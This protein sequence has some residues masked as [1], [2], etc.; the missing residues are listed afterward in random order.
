MKREFTQR[1]KALLLALA[2]ILLFAGY[3]KLFSEPVEEEYTAAQ[4]QYDHVQGDLA[5]EQIKLSSMKKM[6]RTL[7]K[8]EDS[9]MSSNIMI[10]AYDNSGNV[11]VQ[12]DSILKSAASYQV[13]FSD[14]MYGSNLVSRPLKLTFTA[15]NY[16]AAKEI[17][18]GL[19][20]CKYR[21]TLSGIT[22]ASGS[23]A[24]DVRTSGVSV[25]LTVTFYEKL[26]AA[27]KRDRA[28]GS[29]RTAQTA[30]SSAAN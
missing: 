8:L 27:A 14:V 19:Y 15:K 29:S 6:E 3:W 10:P 1:E 5:Q 21:C 25:A 16:A 12:L 20:D 17:L 30:A 9:G 4:V 22:V 7:K 23:D 26:D 28:A 2:I 13:T 18:S 24:G 11:M